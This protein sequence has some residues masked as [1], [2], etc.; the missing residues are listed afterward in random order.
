MNVDAPLRNVWS[1]P[2]AVYA[3][4]QVNVCRREGLRA[5]AYLPSFAGQVSRRLQHPHLQLPRSV[6]EYGVRA[7]HLSEN[8]R[9]IEACLESRDQSR[10]CSH[11]PVARLSVGPVDRAH[12]I[13]R[14]IASLCQVELRLT[15]PQRWCH[16]A[17]ACLGGERCQLPSRPSS[18]FD[19]L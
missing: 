13:R 7:D 1:F 6:L 4:R 17:R 12:Q 16:C 14:E 3:C 9:D 5:M 11:I 15:D 18:Q 8:L 19:S 2:R 10:E